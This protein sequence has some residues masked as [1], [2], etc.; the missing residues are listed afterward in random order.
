[1]CELDEL[2]LRLV[3]FEL[4]SCRD[5]DLVVDVLR[6]G[7]DGTA[8]ALAR[9]TTVGSEVVAVKA[10]VPVGLALVCFVIPSSGRDDLPLFKGE[11]DV[12][13]VVRGIDDDG[14]DFA[15]LGLLGLVLL[16][17]GDG[18]EAKSSYC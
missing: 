8:L 12:L 2:S 14:L 13:R 1:M 9:E 3:Y 15:L 10:K 17:A 5:R 7:F 6:G 16:V 4:V 18:T 11:V